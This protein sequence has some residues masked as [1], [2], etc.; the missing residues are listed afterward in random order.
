MT[1]YNEL[2]SEDEIEEIGKQLNF[3]TDHVISCIL[4]KFETEF[5]FSRK[6]R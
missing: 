5:E 3:E 1:T 6:I 2:L 4:Q